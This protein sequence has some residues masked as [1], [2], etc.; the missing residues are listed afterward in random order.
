MKT[1]Y[2]TSALIAL[3]LSLGPVADAYEQPSVNLGFTSFLD[4]GPPAGPGWYFQQYLQYWSASDL[5]GLPF[6]DTGLDAVIS[7]SQIIYQSDKALLGGTWGVDLI[8]PYVSLDLERGE[9][10]L[11]ENSGGF[12]DLLVGPYIQWGPVMGENGPVFMHRVELQM[13]F[14][15]GSYD[16]KYNINPGS[17][18]FSFNPYWSGTLFMGPRWSASVRIHLLF[19]EANGE[20]PMLYQMQGVDSFRAGRAIHGNFAISYDVV[21]RQFR[22]GLNGFFFKQ[23]SDTEFNGVGD[24]SADEEVIAVGPGMLYSF[25]QEDHL[26]VN[27]YFEYSAENRP[28]G[29][30]LNLRWTHHF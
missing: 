3:T 25:S 12:G 10:P 1:Q 24:P 20:P 28:E 8:V 9:S 29:W 19:N 30:R 14:P 21:P 7:L 2:L 22:V 17:N 11:A 23:T 4:G 26:F 6:P 27:A 13:I 5:K 18:F 16:Q 15:T